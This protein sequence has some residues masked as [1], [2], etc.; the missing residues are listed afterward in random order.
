VRQPLYNKDVLKLKLLKMNR[1]ILLFIIILTGWH[2]AQSQQN[3]MFLR[4][5]WDQPNYL[6]YD[7]YDVQQLVFQSNLPEEK[8]T[9]AAAKVRVV[10]KINYENGSGIIYFK[11]NPLPS[12]I[13]KFAEK[14]GLSEIYINDT[15]ILPSCLLDK[16]ELDIIKTKKEIETKPFYSD[17]NKSGTKENA[18]F[19]IQFYSTKIY[20]MQITDYPRYLYSGYITS[21]T[22]QLEQYKLQL[23]NFKT[24]N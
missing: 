5:N 9:D 11:S 23:Q 1:K 21:Y 22:G 19:N 20:S 6:F 13:R 15:R 2:S 8:I 12:D 14:A 7:T 10:D 17:Y 4:I 3:T 24:K 16:E 18:E